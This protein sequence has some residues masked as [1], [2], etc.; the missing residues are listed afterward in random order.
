MRQDLTN[1]R[2]CKVIQDNG[3]RA[4]VGIPRCHC[5]NL[6][7]STAEE[8]RFEQ[9]QHRISD[10]NALQ[11]NAMRQALGV[12]LDKLSSPQFIGNQLGMRS[13]ELAAL[14]DREHEFGR[15][16][17]AHVS[18]NLHRKKKLAMASLVLQVG[19]PNPRQCLERRLVPRTLRKDF[20]WRHMCTCVVCLRTKFKHTF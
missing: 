10:P 15:G 1:S 19:D 20:C 9:S 7:Q 14:L 13:D 4:S 8:N 6:G 16:L 5:M 2:Q 12:G 11:L 17:R 3:A 18:D